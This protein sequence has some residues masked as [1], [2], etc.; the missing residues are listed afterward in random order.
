MREGDNHN[1]KARGAREPID[2]TLD[3]QSRENRRAARETEERGFFFFF[4]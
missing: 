3:I 1:D 2:K 4:F